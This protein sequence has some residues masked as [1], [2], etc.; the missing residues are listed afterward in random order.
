MHHA[1]VDPMHAR[2]LQVVRLISRLM[3][4][5]VRENIVPWLISLSEQGLASRW[6]GSSYRNML[7]LI[8]LCNI[9]CLI[10]RHESS[11]A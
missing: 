10:I 9:I 4:F 11:R 6:R 5:F 7:Y 2:A 8:I 3:L 1:F